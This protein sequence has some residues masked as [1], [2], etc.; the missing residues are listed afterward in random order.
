MTSKIRRSRLNPWFDIGIDAWSLGA[1]SSAVIALRLLRIAA[2][3]A[4]GDAETRLMVSEKLAAGLE[5]QV[6]A[7]HG[8]LGFSPVGA[9]ARTL[10]HYR[11]KVRANRRR[12][13]RSA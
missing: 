3:G 7:L 4:A 11:R 5:L 8:D 13:Q 6:K 9:T 1:E 10:S 12:L 2:G